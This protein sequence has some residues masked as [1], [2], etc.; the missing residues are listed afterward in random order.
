MKIDTHQ[1]YWRYRPEDFPWISDAMPLLQR[2]W[3]PAQGQAAMR[4]CG[5]DA[6]V[7]VQARCEAQET[8]FLLS[9]AAQAPQI[10]GVVGWADLAAPTL[11][12]QLAA[13]AGQP[14]LCGLRHLLQDE[15]DL[16]G[17][18]D[19]NAFNAGLALLQ[20]QR[21]VYDVLVF[22]HQLPAVTGLCARHDAHWLVLDHVG[23][24]A[25]RDWGPDLSARWAAGLRSLA[26]MPHVVVKLSGLV[27]ETR[28]QGGAGLQARDRSLMFDRF[29]QALDAFGPQRLMYGSDWP[30]CQLA[31]SYA[32]VHQ[33]AH[34]WANS[35]LSAPEQQAFWGGNAIQVYALKGLETSPA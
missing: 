6:V 35:R 27:T 9:L 15:V 8:D 13:W 12:A 17:L 34:D 20:R 5:V 22:D 1:H 24:P 14:A 19:S 31:A 30:V 10:V 21:L 23:K 29:D 16:V 3:L 4:L 7:A 33:L 28:W 32:E 18:V 25:L 26:A 11:A 2:D